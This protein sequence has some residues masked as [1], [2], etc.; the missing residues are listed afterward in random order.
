MTDNSYRETYEAIL[1]TTKCTI[2]I[3]KYLLDVKKFDF[4]WTRP[5]QSDKV[6][7]FFSSMRQLNGSNYNVDARAVLS[8]AEKILRTGLALASLCAN[9]RIEIVHNQ[10]NS[11][12]KNY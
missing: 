4:V 9:V 8:A 10:V 7:S 6:E 1:L 11:K 5:F 3:T 2:A 12:F